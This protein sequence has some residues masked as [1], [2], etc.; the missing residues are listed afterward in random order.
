M[1]VR[2]LTQALAAIRSQSALSEEQWKEV[3]K[4]FSALDK[5]RDGSLSL[6]ARRRRTSSFTI[7]TTNHVVPF[8]VP[9]LSNPPGLT[10]TSVCFRRTLTDRP[11]R[12]SHHYRSSRTASR[13]W[14]SS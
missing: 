7:T 3:N 10:T 1:C 12:L 14:A 5:D 6:K 4:V 2:R 13:A 11:S 9:T 8:I